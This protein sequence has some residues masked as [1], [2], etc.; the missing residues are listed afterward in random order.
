MPKEDKFQ[1]FLRGLNGLEPELPKNKKNISVP[2]G[3]DLNFFMNN[4][5]VG[6]FGTGPDPIKTRGTSKQN[7]DAF[8]NFIS[9]SNQT[10]YDPLKYSKPSAYGAN[11]N[12]MNFDRYYAHP[13]FNKLGFSPWRDNEQYYNKNSTWF[14]DFRR[15]GSVGFNFAMKTMWNVSPFNWDSWS[16]EGDRKAASDYTHAMSKMTST[17]GGFG[18]WV[19][20]FAANSSYTI[21]IL[22]ELAIEEAILA[23]ITAA[24]AGTTAELTIPAAIVE[25]GL[26]ARKLYQAAKMGN[27]MLDAL[28]GMKNINRAKE[29]YSLSK[30]QKVGNFINP[31]SRTTEILMGTDKT[32][33][34]ADKLSALA[35]GTYG[36]ANF[37]RDL[38]EMN[39]VFDEASLE[40]GMVQNDLQKGL[41]D[42][43][44]NNNGRMPNTAEATDIFNK[45]KAG[46]SMATMANIPTIY[47]SNKVVLG[48]ALKGWQP[49]WMLKSGLE[50]VAKT[51][52][53][54]TTKTGFSVIKNKG[55]NKF[56]TKDYWKRVP[57]SIGSQAIRY[58]AANFMEGTQETSQEVI[59]NATKDYYTK[60][61]KDPNLMGMKQV[62]GSMMGG[63][64]S[65]ANAQGLDTF[66]SGFLM[67]GFLQGPQ[68]LLF[69]NAS[70]GYQWL[71]N[72]QGYQQA[73]QDREKWTNTLITSLNDVI[74]NKLEYAKYIDKN[75]VA[76][77]DMAESMAK[78]EA[79]GDR[80]LFEDTKDESMFTHIHTLLKTGKFDYFIESMR[81]LKDVGSEDMR[82]AFGEDISGR[83][84]K[85]IAKAQT[86]KRHHDLID[87]KF[88]NPFNYKAINQTK[89]PEGYKQTKAKWEAFEGAKMTALYGNYQ[90]ARTLERMND[91]KTE[92]SADR[93]FGELLSADIGILFDQKSMVAE[94]DMLSQKISAGEAVDQTTRKMMKDDQNRLDNL[95][96]LWVNT[97]SFQQLLKENKISD[98]SPE[99]RDTLALKDKIKRESTVIYTDSKGNKISGKVQ[100][101]SS[102]K[103]GKNFVTIITASGKKKVGLKNVHLKGDVSGEDMSRM[104]EV[105]AD[106][107]KA[108]SDYIKHLGRDNNTPILNE[109]VENSFSKYLDFYELSVDNR[110]Y[111]ASI[112]MLSDPGKFG[113][114]MDHLTSIITKVDEEKT[115][116]M[117]AAM[118]EFLKMKDANEL[119]NLLFE[120]GVF[121]DKEEEQDLLTTGELPTKFYNVTDKSEVLP[122][123][124]KYDEVVSILTSFKEN[125]LSDEPAIEITT[126]Q[127]EEVK[128]EVK[129]Q[130]VRPT[131]PIAEMPHDLIAELQKVFE[132]ENEFRKKTGEKLLNNNS[133]WQ[134]FVKTNSVAYSIIDSY[135]KRKGLGEIEPLSIKEEADESSFEGFKPGQ[136]KKVLTL[137]EKIEAQLAASEESGSLEDQIAEV[138]KRREMAIR[139]AMNNNSTQAEDDQINAM[140]DAE[141]AILTGGET[142]IAGAIVP[143]YRGKI[144]YATPGLGKTTLANKY[145][146]QI[147]DADNLLVEELRKVPGYETVTN[148]NIGSKI[149]T[150][151]QEEGSE[152]GDA[153]YQR[154]FAQMRVLADEGKTVLTGSK[155]WISKAD[156]VLTSTDDSTL[157]TQLKRK[158]TKDV[159]RAVISYRTEERK[160]KIRTPVEGNLEDIL[161]GGGPVIADSKVQKMRDKLNEIVNVKTRK[162][163]EDYQNSVST[164][165][166]EDLDTFMSLGISGKEIDQMVESK[167][168]ELSKNVNF[169]DIKSGD[170][171]IMK[172]KVRF[173]KLG[174]A[175][176]ITKTK[177]SIKVRPVG[178]ESGSMN[179]ISSKQVSEQVEGIYDDTVQ[180]VIPAVTAED[181]ANSIESVDTSKS[182]PMDE[183]S[184]TFNKVKN[185]TKEDVDKNFLDD[186][187]KC[188]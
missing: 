170:I 188:D 129:P 108:Y 33:R 177:G 171:L 96:N 105:L 147:V 161:F 145:P 100:S 94:M 111:A 29:L 60:I 186:I 152:E 115:S 17:R 120:H 124:A 75:F 24:T 9:Q 144:I 125:A 74:E 37:Y 19:N 178:E 106:L 10:G 23:G 31:L 65:Q 128:P 103:N 154:V 95:K 184:E 50:A 166:Q 164:I 59:S 53:A 73:K 163:L 82:E 119:V 22:G 46:G 61:Y 101:Q 79:N 8:A 149:L 26:A 87:A 139:I 6:N 70:K 77:K 102:D 142:P 155:R 72:K 165:M 18:Q 12:G 158:G 182:I 2:N 83:I 93:S 34:N 183:F 132:E 116:S 52:L 55:L 38:R 113:S 86:I 21:G 80:K 39:L 62:W 122:G 30:M 130:P 137:E 181:A 162:E 180:E 156:V 146:D 67:G 131:D 68:N 107:N 173:G 88:E 90:F 32:L 35:K 4:N 45:S 20:N 118:K 179:V 64:Q 138:E 56:L 141:I 174:L 16:L 117:T 71:T 114:L 48:T 185:Q 11:E 84:D 160:S 98:F 150:F 1:D 57:G 41:I 40:G 3:A 51:P 44:Y 7:S 36:F 89:D 153:L 69:K 121:L 175:A 109:S 172:D 151:F 99:A 159:G 47:F 27:T 136:K 133:D 13:K 135:N 91:L 169:A 104:R 43:F 168:A 15:T 85:V 28:K 187:E 140:F 49:P 42:D 63:V 176:V 58:S 97:L 54:G 110:E 167:K 81:D 14:D 127:T 25:G 66:L 5:N 92:A 126:T 112:N 76:Q 143:E 78:S 134:D 157:A 123:T 148:E